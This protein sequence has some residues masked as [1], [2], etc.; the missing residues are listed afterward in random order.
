VK[1]IYGETNGTK[2]FI[3]PMTVIVVKLLTANDNL[4]KVESKLTE[5]CFH[6]L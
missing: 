3:L 2:A 1:G 5:M 4:N 6:A